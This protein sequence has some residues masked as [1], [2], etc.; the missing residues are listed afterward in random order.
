MVRSARW[1][2]VVVTIEPLELSSRLKRTPVI[3]LT[4]VSSPFVVQSLDRSSSGVPLTDS[5]CLNARKKRIVP[6]FLAWMLWI[7]NAATARVHLACEDEGCQQES[8]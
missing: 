8:P 1:D 2:L 7:V 4:P 6:V 3:A 5:K